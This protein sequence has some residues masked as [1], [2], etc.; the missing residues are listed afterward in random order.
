MGR[1]RAPSQVEG[2][3]EGDAGCQAGTRLRPVQAKKC[4]PGASD[5]PLA[6][7][8]EKCPGGRGE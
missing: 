6:A 2:W 1:Q 8:R 5:D 7:H 4:G 3:A